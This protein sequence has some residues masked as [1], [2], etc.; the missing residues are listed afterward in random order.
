MSLGENKGGYNFFIFGTLIK[1]LHMGKS[2]GGGVGGISRG[3]GVWLG[4]I[5]GRWGVVGGK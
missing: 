4:H 1:N 3:G 5:K 2:R